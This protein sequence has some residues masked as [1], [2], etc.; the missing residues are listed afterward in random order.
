VE[1][2]EVVSGGNQTGRRDST[3]AQPI[4]VRVVDLANQ[5]VPNVMVRFLPATGNG[6]VLPDSVATD[7]LGLARTSWKLGNVGGT[8]SL[9]VN[10]GAA[11]TLTVFATAS[12]SRLVLVSG[13]G[14][15]ARIQSALADSIV[16][17]AL[18]PDSLPLP[19]LAVTFSATSGTVSPVTATTDA[20]GFAK[21]RWT[22]GNAAGTV[23][24]TASAT[25]VIPVS[26]TATA[27]ADTRR[28]L[29]LIAGDAQTGTVG[30]FL[31]AVVRVKV[32]DS[33]SNPIAGETIQWTDSLTNGVT[34]IFTTSLTDVNGFAETSVRLG[35]RV[36]PGLLRARIAG[37]SEKVTFSDTAKVAL[38]GVQ[39]GNLFSCALTSEG[40]SYCWGFNGDGQLAKQAGI[41]TD[42]DRPTTPISATD[43]LLGPFQT[44]R[45]V[46]LGRT[47]ACGVSATKRL[48]CWGT[49]NGTFGN[50]TPTPIDFTSAVTVEAVTSGEAHTCFID[51]D[52]FTWCGGENRL[53]QLGNA[54]T[55]ATTGKNAVRLLNDPVLLQPVRLS[56][57]AAG[58]SFTCGFVWGTTT[59]QCW[60][61]NGVGQLGRGT[62]I[63]H[64]S[65][66]ANVSNPLPALYDSTSLVT[67]VEHAC[68]LTTAGA[69]RCWGGNG[70]GQ[71][72]D[73]TQ[74]NKNVP[75]AV[76]GGLTFVRLA[77]G[78]Y[79]TCGLTSAGV[80]HCWGRNTSGQL[81][82]GS[83]TLRTSPVAVTAG[84][85]TFQSL[86][87]GELHSCGITGTPAT[88][89]SGTTTATG[90]VY[91]WG[92]NEY[93]QLGDG[94][95][96]G[97]NTPVLTPKR[98]V[99]Q[100]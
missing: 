52:G 19:N 22:M 71:L 47:H 82:D 79:H 89:G 94:A 16:V 97:N 1:R 23:T 28:I 46:S 43:S 100:P 60:G 49:G 29:S 4:V 55:T 66:P 5:P 50:T 11:G 9:V 61:D 87:L 95:A 76:A 68:V 39:S 2:L 53:G 36:G 44:F 51:I 64:D 45:Q 20:Q 21:V 24:L 88:A 83:Q 7:A 98:V 57:L 78:E 67:G 12:Q 30:S 91:C 99:Y 58:R 54:T 37:R 81:G 34:P 8:Q 32:T 27:L 14:Q 86:S 63:T 62:L 42:T 90:R 13:G 70:S 48:I 40:R 73:G 75:T 74:V 41:R 92:D 77:A 84:G 26:I 25:G 69:A 38:A 56:T 10:A 17:R 18:T 93:G 59:P 72:G 80:A 96:S 6:T 65:V 3:L 15:S 31:G 35:A 33:L 85:L